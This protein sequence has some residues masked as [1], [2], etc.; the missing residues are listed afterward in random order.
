MTGSHAAVAIALASLAALARVGPVP[1]PAAPA[2]P[3][4]TL[5]PSEF[6]YAAGEILRGETVSHTFVL[7]NTSVGDVTIN[8]VRACCTCATAA[9]KL[10]GKSLNAEET[11][12][13]KQIGTLKPGERTELTFTLDTLDSG[14]GGKDGPIVKSVSVYH[15]GATTSP[16]SLSIAGELVTPYKVEPARLDFGTV[17]EGDAKHASCVVSS[18]RLREFKVLKATCST[19]GLVNVTFTREATPKAPIVAYRVEAEMQSTARLGAYQTLVALTLDHPRVKAI[20][21]PLGA[22]VRAPAMDRR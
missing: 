8:E 5:T 12:K 1:R 18:D 19:E 16:L 14:C 15:T 11:A 10:G 21:I 22:T 3:V 2:A 4:G 6:T 7:N 9:I 20:V 13:C 17:R